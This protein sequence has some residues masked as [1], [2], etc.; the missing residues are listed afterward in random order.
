VDVPRLRFRRGLRFAA[1]AVGWLLGLLA[2]CALLLPLAFRGPR[3]V[4]LVEKFLPPLEGELRLGGG[5]LGI[6]SVFA[7]AVGLPARICL[8]DLT[9][10]DPEGVEVFWAAELRAS[11]AL[12]R[13]PL[14]VV[15]DDLR[16]GVSRWRLASMRSRSTVGFVAAFYPRG[17]LRSMRPRPPPPPPQPGTPPPLTPQQAAA[18][19][20]L[21][22]VI[23]SAHLDGTSAT[24]DFPAW[25]LE[26]K[27]IRAAGSFWASL[28]ARGK[29]PIGFEVRGI[30]ARA[31]GTLRILRPPYANL[32]PFDRARLDWIGTPTHAPADLLLLVAGAT[33]GQSRLSGRALFAGLFAGRGVQARRGMDIDADWERAGDALTAVAASRGLRDLRLGG[34]EARLRA[35][36]RGAYRALTTRFQAAGFDVAFAGFRV[37]DLGL[38]LDLAGPPLRVTL[39]RMSFRAPA[40]GGVEGRGQLLQ[41]G[42]TRVRLTVDRLATGELLPPY[43]RPLLAGTADGWLAARGD[44]ARQSFVLEGMDLQLQRQRRGPLPSAIRLTTGVV[45]PAAS[46]EDRLIGRL[47]SLRY[48]RGRLSVQRLDATA[49]GARLT[50]SATLALPSGREGRPVPHLDAAW[51]VRQVDLRRALPGRGLGGTLSFQARAS[52]PLDDLSARVQIPPGSQVLV[53]DQSYGLPTQL[54]AEI[55]GELLLVPRFTLLPPGGG[56]VVVGGKVVFDEQIALDLQVDGHRL[57]RLPRVSRALP[58][59]VGALSGSLRLR[60][61]PGRTALDGQVRVDASQ[62]SLATLVPSLPQLGRAGL[63]LAGRFDLE[64]QGRRP[65]VLAAELQ[66]LEVE[67]G[68][69]S[70]AAGGCTRLESASAVKIRSIGGRERIE[71][72]PARL[73]GA[74]SD[75]SLSGRLANGDLQARLDGRL[76][77]DLLEPLYR[78]LPIAIS[79]SVQAALQARGRAGAPRVQGT[80]Q[81]AEP[82]VVSGRT[83]P[84]DLRFT[85]G[86]V[87]VDEDRLGVAGLQVVGHGLRLRIDGDVTAGPRPD[88][89]DPVRLR[90][91]GDLRLEELAGSMPEVV[92]QASGTLK[93]SARMSGTMDQPRLDGHLDFGP[94]TARLRVTR[95]NVLRLAVHP[96][97]IEARANRVTIAGL[98]ADVTPGGHLVVGPPGRPATIEIAKLVPFV[99]GQINLPLRGERLHAELP[100]LT[101]HQG[102]LDVTLT[103]DATTGPLRL[104]GRVEL[105]AGSY[106]PAKQP[107]PGTGAAARVARRLPRSMRPATLPVQLDVQVVSNGKHFTIDPGWLPD[108]HLGLDVKVGGTATRPQVKW[109][110]EPR[111]L[112][113]RLMFFLYRL[114]S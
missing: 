77:S 24:F 63:R 113:S 79:G 35:T 82:L 11:V 25:G 94:A 39:D 78:K 70:A 71:L 40:G 58:G 57:D 75:F 50:A 93:V 109:E 36:V 74:G 21:Q 28:P 96:G 53:F 69:G 22:V 83:G 16:P 88:R 1:V 108:L 92:E 73:R 99:L 100:W 34:E 52:G 14:R 55:R 89:L 98:R 13:R 111:G 54:S 37:R 110:A 81:L 76:S 95:Q 91:E 101:L 59:M 27:D 80:L 48:R 61:H 17:R 103:G 41:S 90:V 31:G 20:A 114:F 42:D 15:I 68:C 60:S 45:R 87:T 67:Y 4:W 9:V 2:L 10:R 33:T 86:T 30:D 85:E 56:R 44:L 62:L 105:G 23:A 6:G 66:T 65:P 19:P 29:P 107:R 104:A 46:T 106:R 51:S 38:D 49:F 12:Q 8:R 72:L 26:L 112:Y 43:L 3:L 64:Q 5:E 102:A 97:R 7:L 32:V 47:Q 18:P 84:L